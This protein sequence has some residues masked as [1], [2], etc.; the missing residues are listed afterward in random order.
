MIIPEIMLQAEQIAQ[1]SPCTRRK[2]GVVIAQGPVVWV[3]SCNERVGRCC[4][5]D[6]CVRDLNLA[7]HNRGI[8][9]GAEIHAEAVALLRFGPKGVT[10]M[11]FYLAGFDKH[12]KKIPNAV[13][14]HYCAMMMWWS[15]FGR[16]IVRNEH[17]ELVYRDIWEVIEEHESTYRDQL[18]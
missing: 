13:P 17:D 15:G 2:Y 7:P 11:Q 4:D 10:P 14:C 12:G 3:T 8:E 6:I 9:V 1:I 16:Y 5:G 18:V